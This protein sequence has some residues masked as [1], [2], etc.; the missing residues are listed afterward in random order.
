MPI[1]IDENHIGSGLS[2]DGT[3]LT[4]TGGGGGGG[5]E[6]VT[7]SATISTDDAN[8][9]VDATSAAVTL[10]VDAALT[11]FTVYDSHE[12]FALNNCT[13]DFG[14]GSTKVMSTDGEFMV[15][16]K[17]ATDAWRFMSLGIA[18]TGAV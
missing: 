3:N 14:G 2:F 15:F 16:F 1:I 13:V 9:F 5:H 12:Q 10:T 18:S 8:Y 7:A 6:T 17:D 11:R 4:A